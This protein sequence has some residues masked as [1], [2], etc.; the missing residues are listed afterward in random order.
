MEFRDVL[1]FDQRKRTVELA[2][3]EFRLGARIRELAIGLL[4]NCFE[5]AGIDNV[6]EVAG[7]DEGAVAEFDVGD[8][9]ADPG[10]N[11]NLFDRI[12]PSGEFVPIGDGAFGG[13]GDRDRRCSGRNRRRRLVIAARQA[14]R[15]Q[16]DHRPETAER[17]DIDNSS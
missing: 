3:G 10:A 4:G 12:E 16:N 1:G 2:L 9:P 15:Q 14:N 11:L 5:G 7:L 8:E 13:L 17:T 6:Q